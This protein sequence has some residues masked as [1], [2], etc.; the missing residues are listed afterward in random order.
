MSQLATQTILV[1]F[2]TA[3]KLW[4]RWIAWNEKYCMT[5]DS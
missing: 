3:L 2:N 4:T 1:L 5:K